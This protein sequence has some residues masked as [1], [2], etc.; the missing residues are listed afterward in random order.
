LTFDIRVLHFGACRRLGEGDTHS[1]M[2]IRI[3]SVSVLYVLAIAACAVS[4]NVNGS[5]AASPRQKTPTST[6]AKDPI[7]SADDAASGGD[8][9][10]AFRLYGQ[11]AKMGNSRAQFVLGGMY[12]DADPP[13]IQEALKWYRLAAAQGFAEA[14]FKLGTMFE[15][16]KGV[17]EDKQEAQKWYLMAAAQGFAEA[18]YKLGLK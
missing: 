8:Y 17:Q 5:M 2:S 18:E 7:N 9:W 14:Q 3:S 15:Q 12:E 11:S 1:A 10:T 4:W 16:G 13:K 6:N